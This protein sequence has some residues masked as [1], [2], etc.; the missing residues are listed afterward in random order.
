LSTFV[1]FRTCFDQ[2]IDETTI[3]IGQRLGIFATSVRHGKTSRTGRR[4]HVDAFTK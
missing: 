1:A 4:F 3:D 2:A